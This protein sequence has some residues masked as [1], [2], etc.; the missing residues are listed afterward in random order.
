MRVH[1]QRKS[2]ILLPEEGLISDWQ[3]VTAN[4]SI[5]LMCSPL[6]WGDLRGTKDRCSK[7]SSDTLGLHQ[8]V[9]PM[10]VVLTLILSVFFI[11]CF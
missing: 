11:D 1:P 3:I 10:K 4:S 8:P 6:Y 7:Y 5:N 2:G 9:V